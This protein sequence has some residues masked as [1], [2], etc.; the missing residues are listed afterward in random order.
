MQGL[1]QVRYS[2]PATQRET[3]TFLGL[4]RSDRTQEGELAW[5][6]NLSDRRFPYLSP[7]NPRSE[8]VFTDPTAAFSWNGKL[9]LVNGTNLLYDGEVIGTV[10][11][12]P[13]QFAVVNTK[14]CIFPDGVYI[15]LENETF[16]S[17]GAE[18]SAVA[19]SAV[20]T[21]N[22]LTLKT[23]TEIKTENHHY[24]AYTATFSGWEQMDVMIKTY[25]GVTWNGS[26]WSLSGENEVDI[27]GWGSEGRPAVG[28]YV[29]FAR[30]DTSGVYEPNAREW[31]RNS[32][33]EESG[34][35]YGPVLD[36]YYGKI[37]AYSHEYSL[38]GGVNTDSANLEVM[39]LDGSTNNP[40]L[41]L[42][43]QV[44]DRV[45][46]SGC[47][48]HKENNSGK[49]EYLAIQA[50][51]KD[52]ITFSNGDFTAGNEAGTVKITRELPELDYICEKDNR[53][54]G[55]SSA[56]RTIYA[57]ALGDPSNFFTFDG[58]D[59]DS[60]AAAVGSEGN[61]TG[62]CKY[63][64]TVLA[65]KERTLHKILGSNPSDFQMASYQYEGVME[66]SYKSLVNINEVL[67][68]L[69]RDGVFAYSG[70]APQL[71]SEKLGALGYRDGVGGTD[72][73]RYF[74]SARDRDGNWGLYSYSTQTGLWF[75][76]DGK[77]AVDFC[78]LDDG[79]AFLSGHGMLF[80]NG[81]EEQ[82]AWSATFT[83]F[84][85][86]VQGKKR[87]SRLLLRME[88]PEGSFLSVFLRCDGGPW[89]Q[90]GN[91]VGRSSGVQTVLAAPNRCDKFEI[92]LAGRGE[93]ALLSM[94]REY[95]IGSER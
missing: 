37:T 73:I 36:R 28:R 3:V 83:P 72:G 78:R 80:M 90:I 44:G 50:I 25:S 48:T 91:L 26:S 32:D 87:F 24:S 41:T 59:T 88:V 58:L 2:V 51:T 1:P 17:L 14:L 49:D 38:E 66:G 12:G 5:C 15:D 43:F 65:W 76:E 13:K 23:S 81:G 45:K 84:Y 77:Q 10:S 93:C 18:T 47:T 21:K 57:S 4:N 55:V 27:A 82:V 34:T 86:T 63:G 39:V 94:L 67:F 71:V 6:E 79:L 33:D 95:R 42:F 53:L 46:L 92:N 29:L 70:S 22:T 69:G 19:N 54:W 52:S 74:L 7:R 64:N 62:L 56:E 20:F 31:Y 35:E 75:R 9:V 8:Q 85:E 89:R 16:R 11:A 61:F 40:E 68:Y 60:Y 30:T